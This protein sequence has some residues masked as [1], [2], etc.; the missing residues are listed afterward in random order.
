MAT[1]R[2]VKTALEEIGV[3][4]HVKAR[5]NGYVTMQLLPEDV[6]KVKETMEIYGIGVGF[7][8]NSG[9]CTYQIG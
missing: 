4:A 7:D 9:T 8:F 2:E 6:P 3:A 1:V 5:G